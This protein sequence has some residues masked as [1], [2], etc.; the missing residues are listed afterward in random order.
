MAMLEEAGRVITLCIRGS[1]P[2]FPGILLLVLLWVSGLLIV[3][4]IIGLSVWLFGAAFKTATL[5]TVLSLI[6]QLSVLCVLA[7]DGEH[8]SFP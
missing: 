5:V 8:S 6:G 3:P 2:G 1:L 7:R 4:T